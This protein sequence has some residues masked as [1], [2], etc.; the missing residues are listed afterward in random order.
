[1][2]QTIGGF[3]QAYG[4]NIS[5]IQMKGDIGRGY[6]QARAGLQRG[7]VAAQGYLKDALA[8]INEYMQP[9]QTS[10]TGALASLSAL[11]ADPNSIAN[12]AAY[13]FQESEGL[14]MLQQSKA[15]SGKYFSGET[16][17][18][19]EKFGQGLAAQSYGAEWARQQG[20]AN[21]GFQAAGLSA[22][23]MDKIRS[24]MA[25]TAMTLGEDWASL[26]INQGR[27]MSQTTAWEQ[28]GMSSAHQQ[29]GSG[30]DTMLGG[31][32]GGG[33]GGMMG[34]MG[35]MGG[36]IICTAMNEAYG[37]GKYR[38][39]IWVQ[40]GK[41]HMTEDHRIGYHQL[42]LKAVR[43]GFKSGDALPNRIV[44]V[45]L[46]NIARHRTA[47]LRAVLRNSKRDKLGMAYR[48]VLEPLCRFVGMLVRK[49]IIKKTKG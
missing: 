22:T 19:I 43:Y 3:L 30:V 8:S 21:M 26:A 1:M 29:I 31:S 11:E 32:G 41:D 18:D 15:A 34:G 27:D 40:Y 33:G 36:S 25:G 16:L 20:L 2:G 39:R 46:E 47:D 17:K 48:A 4:S 38:N 37:F 44:R 45:V 24:T 14:R 12:T 42:F 13:K 7:G 5:S 49:K 10:G 35:S 28:Q 6:D 23:E 9:Y